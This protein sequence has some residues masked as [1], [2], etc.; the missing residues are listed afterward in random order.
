MNLKHITSTTEQQRAAL[1]NPLLRIEYRGIAS[2]LMN[3]GI[4]Q[5]A[6]FADLRNGGNL[7]RQPI[8]ARDYA[9]Y[10]AI[11]AAA[12]AVGVVIGS[13][14]IGAFTAMNIAALGGY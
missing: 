5:P 4:D 1:Q 14:A 11:T 3:G 13:L 9:R 10:L 12:V 6:R 8:T 2:A 7:P